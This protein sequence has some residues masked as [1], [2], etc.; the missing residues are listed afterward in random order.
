MV[1]QEMKAGHLYLGKFITWGTKML[2]LLMLSY[3]PLKMP[4]D[5]LQVSR[6]WFSNN[7]RY[8]PPH[9][10]DQEVKDWN[11]RVL[12]QGLAASQWQILT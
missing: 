2:T 5:R 6:A 8:V 3:F 12:V 7:D 4:S 11:S 10:T 9:L 1:D